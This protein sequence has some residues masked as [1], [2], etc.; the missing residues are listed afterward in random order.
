MFTFTTRIKNNIKFFKR[1][2]NL[3]T[4]LNAKHTIKC[5]EE[6]KDGV[7]VEYNGLPHTLV[8]N[9]YAE[10]YWIVPMDGECYPHDV[11]YIRAV[12]CDKL[13]FICFIIPKNA[14]TSVLSSA[15]YYDSY[16]DY[17]GWVSPYKDKCLIYPEDYN[18]EK[19]KNYKHF[20]ILENDIRRFIRTINFEISVGWL[21][22]YWSNNMSNDK[23]LKER[24]W[25]I[26]YFKKDEHL[27]RQEDYVENIIKE[28]FNNS[29][30]EFEK[31]V[32]IVAL[33]NFPDWFK[34]TFGV[35][36]L[37]RNVS[38]ESV[39][40]FFWDKMSTEQ[41]NN[42]INYINQKPCRYQIK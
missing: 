7:K 8:W 16:P 4:D 31:T 5:D 21:D 12:K 27:V 17:K 28:F 10:L 40:R 37:K 38:K 26:K 6:I 15:L 25:G 14:C 29:T 39:K 20:I 23:I 35:E 41:K 22:F 1:R 34:K 24:L 3:Y 13:K 19:Y 32:E 18:K 30:E 11:R 9:P 2:G 33:Q 42:I 36:R